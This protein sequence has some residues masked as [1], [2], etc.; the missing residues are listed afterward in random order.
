[1]ISELLLFAV[2]VIIIGLIIY[3]IYT[4]KAT[5]QHTPPSSER[6]EKMENLKTGYVD[7]LKSAHFKS[8]YKLFSGN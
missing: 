4:R 2:C 5:Q 8:F 1:M 6:Y 7:K 3:G